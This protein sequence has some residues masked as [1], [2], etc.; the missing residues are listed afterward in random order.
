MRI[1]PSINFFIV[2]VLSFVLASTTLVSAQNF[3]RVASAYGITG[4]SQFYAAAINSAGTFGFFGTNTNPGIAV[5]FDLTTM[6]RS[7]NPVG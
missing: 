5:K 4:E 1:I 3:S 7:G 2:V 6:T